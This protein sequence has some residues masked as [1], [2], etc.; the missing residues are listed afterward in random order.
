MITL[1]GKQIRAMAEFA[2]YS[3]KEY[4]QPYG[5]LEN[6]CCFDLHEDIEVKGDNDEVIKGPAICISEYPEEGYLTL[7]ESDGNEHE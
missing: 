7:S 2:G 5:E 1:T 4:K 3:I 6:E